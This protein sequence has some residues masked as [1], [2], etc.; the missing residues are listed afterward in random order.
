MADSPTYSMFHKWLAKNRRNIAA[1][2][3]RTVIYSGMDDV[4][5]VY[6]QLP[7]H[8]KTFRELFGYDPGWVSLE[9]VLKKI[10]VDWTAYCGDAPP[11]KAVLALDCM[12][13]FAC[14][15]RRVS[16]AV[17]IREAQQI[18]LNLSAWYVKN[19]SGDVFVFEGST[20]KAYPDL[21]L[22][23]IPVLL[24]N[25]DAKVVEAYGQK[26]VRLIPKSKAAW[27]KYRADSRKGR[28]AGRM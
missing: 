28:E 7:E 27:E 21:L 24:K 9:F 23:E 2:K 22:A 11:P 4:V 15:V 1:P 8:A 20:L 12:W 5:P 26:L 19:A 13:D 25:K 10:K 17:T 14:N 16:G 3:D 18:W 6:K